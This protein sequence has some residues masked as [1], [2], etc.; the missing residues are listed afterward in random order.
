MRGVDRFGPLRE[1][2]FRLLWL[3]RTG[4]AVGDS[5]IPVALIWAVGHDLHGGA[6]GVGLV[7]AC[8]TVGGAS[9]TLAGG[10]WA[11][12]LPRRAVMIS[13]DL[14]RLG[15]QSATA[16]LLFGGVA[17]VWELAVL[18][19]ATGAAGG[20][21]NPASTALIPQ[22]VSA[23]RLQE[24]NAL[25]SL[26]RSATSVFG[27]GVSGAIVAVA[28]AGW[29]FS[30]DAVSFLVSAAFVAA[31]RLGPQV[32]PAAQ[33]FWR[34]LAD[35][36]REVRRH[37]W[38]TAGFL[39]YAVGNF[40]VGVYIVVGS[41]VAIHHLG[42]AP[43]WGLIVGSAAFGGV[44]GGFVAYRIRPSHPVAMAFAIWTLC[45]LPPF[46]LVRPF[47]L[48]AVMATA[49]LFGGSILV[50]NT[51]FETAM[52]Q[53]V[54]PGRLARVASIDLV[55]SFCLMPAGQALAGP[56]STGLGVHAT[57]ILAGTLMCVPN[58]LVLVLVREVRDVQR[59]EEPAPALAGSV[60]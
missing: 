9:V 27:P 5:L 6:T 4:S 25:L 55:L 30:I 7:L 1:R 23:G 47:P 13:A 51:L 40:G 37:R 24:A 10:V 17:H 15:S 8:Y 29:V 16:V 3:G 43:A 31:M 49:L 36:W 19:A 14:F 54:E 48:P 22:T 35:G 45:A 59:R 2:P 44:L 34:D 60:P 39:G 21:F 53:E 12:R 18:Q 41:L 20:F 42:G 32:R 57:L 33:R 46:A 52:Q 38:L 50:G 28:G 26:S 11:D 56:I 58:F